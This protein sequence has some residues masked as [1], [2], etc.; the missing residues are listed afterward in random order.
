VSCRRQSETQR[1]SGQRCVIFACQLMAVTR[2][3]FIVPSY[4]LR[5]KHSPLFQPAEAVICW[6]DF[7]KIGHRL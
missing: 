3:L 2:Q 1:K 5:E 4:G 6:I 7:G